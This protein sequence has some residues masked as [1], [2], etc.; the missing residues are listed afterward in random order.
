MS[1][2]ARI[3]QQIEQ[4]CQSMR[5]GFSGYA[6]TARHDIISQKYNLLGEYRKDLAR[7]VG[8]EEAGKI[9]FAAYTSLVE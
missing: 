6:V 9:V 3:K 4:E 2:I 8:D 5:L 7:L 1:E